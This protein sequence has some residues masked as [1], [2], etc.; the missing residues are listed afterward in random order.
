MFSYLSGAA[1]LFPYPRV[2]TAPGQ[3][4]QAPHRSPKPDAGPL[5]LTTCPGPS[6]TIPASS[7]PLSISRT[8]TD[9]FGRR[10]HCDDSQR[11]RSKVK[12]LWLYAVLFIWL[13]TFVELQLRAEVGQLHR[14]GVAAGAG[15]VAEFAF[16][17]RN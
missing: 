8:L 13:C 10:V 14:L 3:A 11:A 2:P 15:D 16:K 7:A 9:G 12:V 1:C 4:V 5:T 17:A 6:R